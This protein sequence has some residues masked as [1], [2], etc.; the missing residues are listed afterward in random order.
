MQSDVLQLV[1]RVR[2]AMQRWGAVL[3]IFVLDAE[4]TQEP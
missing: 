4:H 3:D 1:V 2:D